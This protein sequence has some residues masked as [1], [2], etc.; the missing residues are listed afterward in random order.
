[1]TRGFVLALVLAAAAPAPQAGTLRVLFVGNSLTEANDLP[2]MV[3]RLARASGWPGRI[4]CARVTRP[5]SS[6]EDHWTQGDAR[7]AIRRGGWTHV[8]LQQGPSSISESREHLRKHAALFA[9][10]IRASGAEVVLY[11]V[12]PPRDRLAFL[13]DV[14]GSYRLAAQDVGGRLVA[15]GEAWAAAWARDP[16][17]P[18]YGGDRFHPSPAGTYLAAVLFVE[19]LTGRALDA[20]PPDARR[21]LVPAGARL[22]PAQ[23]ESVHAAAASVR[24]DAR[25]ARTIAITIDDLPTVSV[26]GNGV[27]RAERITRDLLAALDRAQVPAIRFVNEQKL[28]PGGG[29]TQK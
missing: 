16:S 1:M 12:W 14:T 28:Q 20:L 9:R 25:P 2:A 21:A 18:L 5:G 29:K 8:V 13:P 4:E 26:L 22:T 7:R 24:Q 23:I 3:E 6:L 10:E 17:L 15:V 11:G 27:E 19:A